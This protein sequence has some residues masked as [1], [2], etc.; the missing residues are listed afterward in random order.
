M[1]K[2]IC[3]TLDLEPDFGGRIKSY[4][5]LENISHFL[6]IIR[7]NRIN[8]TTFAAG[9]LLQKKRDVIKK[10]IDAGS[11]IE[12]HSYSHNLERQDEDYEIKK[13]RKAYIRYF[14]KKPLGYRSP[15]GM[16]T[17]KGLFSLSREGFKYDSSIYPTILLGRYNN[18][19]YPAYPFYFDDYGLIELPFSVIPKIKV[20]LAM[21]YLQPFGFGI[22]R[23]MI[24]IFGLP[25]TVVFDFHMWNLYKPSET[26]KLPLKWKV[27]LANNL[28]NGMKM[29]QNLIKVFDQKGYKPI[30]MSEL[31]IL[32]K[33]QLDKGN[34]TKL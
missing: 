12:L 23:S 22:S 4:S 15:K 5:S 32:A 6:E 24:D 20:P 18:L 2:L 10:L 9:H 7:K 21:G 27:L 29:F 11:E 33:E 3:Y 30:T 14:G 25:N 1:K 34:L 26:N 13:S 16:I 31:Y 19:K 28:D 17:K 8:L